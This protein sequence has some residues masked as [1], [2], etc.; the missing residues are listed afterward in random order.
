MNNES[1]T[2]NENQSDD[3]DESYDSGPMISKEERKR[4]YTRDE[5]EE[6]FQYFLKLIQDFFDEI[7][8]KPC[9]TVLETSTNKVDYHEISTPLFYL[10][11]RSTHRIVDIHDIISHQDTTNSSSSFMK[12]GWSF[13]IIRVQIRREKFRNLGFG[14]RMFKYILQHAPTDMVYIECV[15]SFPMWKIIKSCGAVR[16]SHH[17]HIIF[18]SDDDDS[19]DDNKFPSFLPV[20]ISCRYFKCHDIG[21]SF[22]VPINSRFPSS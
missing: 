7:A 1:D 14:T 12:G 22:Y 10:L 8:L 19:D 15:Q 16:E 17:P 21:M 2:E 9:R 3:D 20:K 18:W 6:G 4:I 11:V 5:F 13:E